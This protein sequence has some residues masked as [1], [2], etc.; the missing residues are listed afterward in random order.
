MKIYKG[1]EHAALTRCYGFDNRLYLTV[2][3]MVPFEISHRQLLHEKII[4]KDCLEQLRDFEHLDPY[5]IAKKNTDILVQGAA[6]AQ[7]STE[8]TTVKLHFE[9]IE[10]T[11]LV[12]G[13]RYWQES[14]I[15]SQASEAQKFQRLEVN[16]RNAFGGE[17]FSLNP[18]GKGVAPQ[19]EL[20]HLPNIEY[21][22]DRQL[23]PSQSVS[24]ASF[25]PIGALWQPRLDYAGTYNQ[26]WLELH[27]PYFPADINW[28][29]FNIAPVDQQLPFMLIGNEHFYLQNMN[30]K[31]P[32]LEGQLPG[33]RVRCFV[34]S[35]ENKDKTY[36]ETPMQLDTCWLFPDLLTGV[37][38]F[39]GQ[40]AVI[41]EDA[42]NISFLQIESEFLN[43]PLDIQDYK[44]KSTDRVK[45]PEK[46]LP[47]SAHDDFDDFKELESE[48]ESLFTKNR[49]K[50]DLAKQ[51]YDKTMVDA[52]K[53]VVKMHQEIVDHQ[54]LDYI[55]KMHVLNQPKATGMDMPMFK[56]DMP[57][58]K[59]MEQ[60]RGMQLDDFSQHMHESTAKMYEMMGKMNQ[61]VKSLDV[62]DPTSYDQYK[63]LME[64]YQENMQVLLK[65]MQKVP[66]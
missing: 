16:Y 17:E 62:N 22:H 44:K 34:E 27:W 21:L 29:Y 38:V 57:T 48:L 59:G 54:D 64:Q 13:D 60:W 9:S 65:S 39:H 52:K 37:M 33:M 41:D 51:E 15:G 56:G 26:E 7:E 58:P 24:P 36:A 66:G 43:N 19:K 45:N 20:W 47:K 6:Y 30:A 28:Q 50:M 14:T 8:Q 63:Q 5:G 49:K 3:I 55:K 23:Q 46:Y 10:K 32:R 61:S 25:G 53:K 11:L 18:L 40:V 4:W 42:S 1:T 12:S 31:Y 2:S 35:L